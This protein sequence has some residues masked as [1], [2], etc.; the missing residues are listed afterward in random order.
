MGGTELS[1]MLSRSDGICLQQHNLA[2]P[3]IGTKI[4]S[5]TVK[6]YSVSHGCLFRFLFCGQYLGFTDKQE[7][8][9]QDMQGR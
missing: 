2:L 7:I 6:G 3:L 5:L 1:I 8:K 4:L 9:L